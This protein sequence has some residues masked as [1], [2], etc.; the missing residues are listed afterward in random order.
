MMKIPSN[1]H[2]KRLGIS[3]RATPPPSLRYRNYTLNL[4]QCPTFR[5]RRPPLPLKP[6]TSEVKYFG[7]IPYV[8]PPLHPN[9]LYRKPPGLLGNSR[10]PE[11]P[12]EVHHSHLT[13]T[14]CTLVETTWDACKS[15]HVPCFPTGNMTQSKRVAYSYHGC[16]LCTLVGIWTL[17]GS[18][19]KV[20]SRGFLSTGG[21]G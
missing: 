10:N 21:R 14:R 6:Q 13:S 9:P 19:G 3:G 1:I 16:Q 12:G 7:C 15:H 17:W 2:T 8:P 4:R 20:P 11:D 18:P 5:L